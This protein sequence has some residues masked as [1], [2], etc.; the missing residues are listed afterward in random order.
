MKSTES[1]PKSPPIT[2]IPK[3]TIQINPTSRKPKSIPNQGN[4][5][6]TKEKIPFFNLG[7]K[8]DWRKSTNKKIYE[9]IEKIFQKEMKELGYL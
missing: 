6:I 3:I 1:Q 4:H 8:R 9:K 2:E 7:P 5:K